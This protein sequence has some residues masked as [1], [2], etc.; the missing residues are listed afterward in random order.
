[1]SVLDSFPPLWLNTQEAQFV[2]EQGLSLAYG[3]KDCTLW[4]V[5]FIAFGTVVRQNF[6]CVRGC[7]GRNLFTLPSVTQFPFTP[8]PK[9]STSLQE[10]QR[11]RTNP[12]TYELH[13]ELKGREKWLH[14][15]FSSYQVDS[16]VNLPILSL[17]SSL[18]L[19]IHPTTVSLAAYC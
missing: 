1:M 3:S 10:H 16:F 6:L 7:G 9:H 15:E 17:E 12:A 18:S 5:G 19:Q 8:Q 14:I 11:L 2:R 13:A 4:S